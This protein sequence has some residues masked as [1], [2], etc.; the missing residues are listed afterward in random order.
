[1]D[2]RHDISSYVT[3][4]KKSIVAFNTPAVVDCHG[5]KLAEFLCFGKA[6]L[7]TKLSRKLPKELINNK[8]LLFTDGSQKDLEE[9]LDLLINDVESRDLLK[10]NARE[11]FVSELSPRKVLEKI[12]I[13]S[14]TV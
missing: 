6:I 1:M 3:K 9:K 8:H 13:Q 12:Q 7:S 4:T 14:I 2:K 10:R 5:W 11:Y